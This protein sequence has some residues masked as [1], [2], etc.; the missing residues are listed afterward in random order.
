M[1]DHQLA[2]A[3]SEQALAVRGGDEW[4]LQIKASALL[5]QGDFD[6]ALKVIEE[7]VAA[8]LPRMEMRHFVKQFLEQNA[9]AKAIKLRSLYPE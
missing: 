5:G 1:G 7:A 4:V 9:Y 6:T 2:L 8:G 3:D